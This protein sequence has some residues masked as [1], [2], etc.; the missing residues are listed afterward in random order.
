[1]AVVKPIEAPTGVGDSRAN[2]LEI[3]L[4]LVQSGSQI[5]V[6][7]VSGFSV[8]L[9]PWIGCLRTKQECQVLMNIQDHSLT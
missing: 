7:T 4:K 6:M 2:P 5:Q 1:M 8:T 3:L 9:N